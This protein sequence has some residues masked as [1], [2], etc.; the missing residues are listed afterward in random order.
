[1]AQLNI[2]IDQETK[3]KLEEV[4]ARKGRSVSYIV[5][6]ALSK[7]GVLKKKK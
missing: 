7:S 3:D 1:M 5:R 4:A 2:Y 6:T